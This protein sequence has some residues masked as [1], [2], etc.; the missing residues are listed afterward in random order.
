MSAVRRSLLW[1]LVVVLF[2]IVA[3]M[4]TGEPGEELDTTT[5]TWFTGPGDL[6]EVHP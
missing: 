2:T 4:V 1:F 5:T 6:T 3:V